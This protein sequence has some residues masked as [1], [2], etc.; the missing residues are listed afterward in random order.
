MHLL[1][2][3]LF[4]KRQ[5]DETLKNRPK[6][7]LGNLIIIM[8]MTMMMISHLPASSMVDEGMERKPTLVPAWFIIV[9]IPFVYHGTNYDYD[10]DYH[11]DNQDGIVCIDGN[12]EDVV[13]TIMI[14]KMT[15]N[16]ITMKMIMAMMTW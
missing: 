14:T 8:T 5:G 9:L 6:K 10:Y 16:M 15:M 11:Y 12:D 2:P 3:D 13:A 4:Q 7:L 1:A